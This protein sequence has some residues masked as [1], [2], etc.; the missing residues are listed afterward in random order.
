M[1]AVDF[2]VGSPDVG[3]WSEVLQLGWRCG[4]SSAFGQTYNLCVC[5]RWHSMDLR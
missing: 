2:A 5:V 3:C 4:M 1:I